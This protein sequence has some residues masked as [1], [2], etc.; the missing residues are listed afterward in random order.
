MSDHTSILSFSDESGV[1]SQ[2][3]DFFWCETNETN[4]YLQ[5]CNTTTPF[6]ADIVLVVVFDVV[7]I[8]VLLSYMV[9]F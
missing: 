2:I 1:F 6:A 9:M 8:H 4:N 5:P 3:Y 7:G